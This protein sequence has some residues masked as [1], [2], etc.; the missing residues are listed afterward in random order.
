MVNSIKWELSQECNLKCKHCFV[1]KVN[2]EN[3]LSLDE[4]KKIIDRLIENNI[5]HIMFSSKEPFM[6]KDFIEI[7][8]YC[9]SKGIIISIVTNGTLFN[10]EY[11]KE[12]SRCKVKIISISL[13]GITAQS[14]DF[15]RGKGSF[16]KVMNSIH[17]INEI[18]KIS[19]REIPLALQ[20][21]LT[22]KNKKEIDK[23]NEFF[24]ESPFL[25]VN[26]GDITLVGN[27]NDNKDLKLSE[28]EY[29]DI[30]NKL[31]S[32]YSNLNKP[33]YILHLKRSNIYETLY[34]NLKFDLSMDLVIPSCAVYHVYN[35]ILP[36]GTLCSCVALKDVNLPKEIELYSNNIL[37][38]KEFNNNY[39]SNKIKEF[40]KYKK[41]DFCRKCRFNEKCEMCLLICNDNESIDYFI[42]RCENFYL[43]LLNIKEGILNN[44]IKF[45][46]NKKVYTSLDKDQLILYRYYFSGSV[47]DMK[48]SDKK[49]ID[50]IEDIYKKNAFVHLNEYINLNSID[51]WIE[52]LILND[53]ISV[54]I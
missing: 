27:A 15:I 23:M 8:K 36:D 19:K 34:Y 20:I 50:F 44:Q 29:D 2:Y 32:D 35:S 12:L 49:V 9:R 11:I 3:N 28:K 4:N 31:L 47:V 46:L 52:E 21:S 53:F 39:D 26:V 41:R 16:D 7:I 33:K 25:T 54:K 17:K 37:E 24:N 48:I 51:Y 10:D 6:Y 40:M 30:V 38:S 45:K 43:K 22:T 42:N 18:N 5:S 13:E 14:N 1:G